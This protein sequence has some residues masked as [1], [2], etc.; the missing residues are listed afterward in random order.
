MPTR[1]GRNPSGFRRHAVPIA[2][3]MVASLFTLAPMIA[4]AP[5]M[6]PWG[7]IMFLAWRA[8]QRSVW[9]VWMGVPLG[10]WDDIFS[11]A[12]PGTSVLLWTLILIGFEIID[13]R[14]IWRDFLQEWGFASAIL[15]IVI[16]TSSLI[17]TIIVG[18]AD[19]LLLLPQI[20]MSAFIFPLITRLCSHLDEWRLR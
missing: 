8:L 12:V 5:T 11:G 7:L 20:T 15:A 10:L 9:P 3:T 19:P 17:S 1:I 18:P 16:L 14:M 13:R 6:P 2:S 4:V